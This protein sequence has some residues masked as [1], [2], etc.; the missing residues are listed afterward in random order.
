MEFLIWFLILST[1]PPS[2]PLPPHKASLSEC[3]ITEF[4][5]RPAQ[6]Q[7]FYQDS[8]VSPQQGD[9][10][11]VC[12]VTLGNQRACPLAAVAVG[13]RY[14]TG[15]VVFQ[16][17]ALLLLQLRRCLAEHQSCSAAEYGVSAGS[18][19]MSS[20]YLWILNFPR[21]CKLSASLIIFCFNN[22]NL[23]SN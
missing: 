17:D 12:L 9:L 3:P 21:L 6:T 23:Q 18:Q 5:P 11:L 13:G 1:P 4:L 2:L 8:I 14:R 7:P 16:T 10:L 19:D 15:R 22:Q 20:L